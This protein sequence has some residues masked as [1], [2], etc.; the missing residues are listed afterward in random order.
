MAEMMT[1]PICGREFPVTEYQILDNGN[2]ACPDCFRAEKDKE[3]KKD[4]K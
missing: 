4:E 3:D 2:P 1:C